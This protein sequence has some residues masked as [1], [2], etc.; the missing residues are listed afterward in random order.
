MVAFFKMTGVGQLGLR[1]PTTWGGARKGAGRPP[2]AGRRR[3]TPHRSRPDHRRA[4]PVH[5]T[6]RAR[7][8]LDS[9][10]SPRVFAGVRA[11]IASASS[12]SFRIIH[13]SVQS[14]HLHLV[15]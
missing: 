2:I 13:F 7:A 10:R 1:L 14:D 12:S 11:A 9:F 6:L 5:L 15:V 3:P 8:E 4:N